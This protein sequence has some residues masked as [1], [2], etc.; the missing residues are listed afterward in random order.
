MTIDKKGFCLLE[1][2]NASRGGESK[3][4]D[5]LR[6]HLKIHTG[7]GSNWKIWGGGLLIPVYLKHTANQV[8]K[9]ISRKAEF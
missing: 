3:I 2:K 8:D 6:V 7:K 4:S 1:K 5:S 9:G